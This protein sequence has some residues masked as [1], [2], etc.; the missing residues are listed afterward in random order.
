MTLTAGMRLGPYE[1]VAPL[2]AGGMGEVYRARDTKLD[3]DVAVKVLPDGVAADAEALARFE[4]EAKAVAAVSHPNVLAI[5][6]FG[7]DRD[8][9]YIVTELLEGES[10]RQ[11]LQQ[12]SIPWRKAV[13]VGTS[14]ADGLAAAH[15]KGIIHRDLKPENIFLTSDG[16][17]KILDF[18][19]ARAQQAS[20]PDDRTITL[21]TKPGTVLGTVHY[22]SPEQVRGRPLDART[23]IFSLG[24]VLFEMITG[25]RAFR[26]DTSADITT[27]ILTQDPATVSSTI[28]DVVPDL[29]RTIAR[30][31]EKNARQRFQSS[32]D[33]AFTLRSILSGSGSGIASAAG[34]GV[35]GWKWAVGALIVMLIVAAGFIWRPIRSPV[36]PGGRIDSLL[37][38]PFVEQSGETDAEFLGE[39]IAESVINSLLTMPNL[40]VIPRNT[41]IRYK[42]R[43]QEL[44]VIASELNVRAVLTGRVRELDGRL[45]VRASLEDTKYRRQIWGEEY[46]RPRSDILTIERDIARRISDAL[47]LQLSGEDV[48]RR[49]KQHTDNPEAY[50][51]YARGRF[52]WNKRTQGGFERAIALYDD[53]IRIDPNYALAYAG[54]ADSYLLLGVYHYVRPRGAFPQALLAVQTALLIDN[55]LAEAHTAL[56]GIRIWSEWDWDG[57]ETAF[58]RA[59]ELAPK[60]PTAHHWY[61]W[62]LMAMQRHEEA[63]REMQRA[64][65]LDPG[66]LI[67]NRDVGSQYLFSRQLDRAIVQFRRT[68]EM[69]PNFATARLFLGQALRQKQ[70]YEEAIAEFQK[71]IDLV[72]LVLEVVG[73]LAYTYALADRVDEALAE[74]RR[75]TELS[76]ERYVPAGS[77]ALIHIGLGNKDQAF[78]WLEKAYENREYMVPLLNVSPAYDSLR[79]DPRFDDLL[80]RVGLEGVS[81]MRPAP[82]LAVKSETGKVKLV[83]L[84]FEDISPAPEAWFGDGLTE[85]LIAQLSRLSPDK[86][87]VIASTTAMQYKGTDKRVRQIGRELDIDYVVEGRVQRIDDRVRI[88]TR[89]VR[90]SD[91]THVWSEDFDRKIDDVFAL[92]SEVVSRI[93]EGIQM[94]L[95]PTEEAQL[96]RARPVDPDALDAYLEGIALAKDGTEQA[97]RSALKMFD[98]AIESDPKFALAHVGRADVFVTL[99]EFHVPP[100]EAMPYAKTAALDALALDEGLPE[101]LTALARVQ[102]MF[103]WDFPTAE[104]T[105][106]RAMEL[107]GS[108]TDARL[109]YAVYLTAMKRGDEAIRQLDWVR[110]RD[111]AS[112]Y[113]YE[114][115][116]LVAYMTRRYDRV[117]RDCSAAI[118]VD[119]E[120]WKARSWLGLAHAQRGELAEG[121]HHLRKALTQSDNSPVVAAMLGS[122][123]AVSG[124]QEEARTIV[125]EVKKRESSDYVCPY[126]LATVWIGLDDHDEAFAEMDRACDGRAPCMPWLQVD[127]RLDPIRSDPRFDDLLRRVGFE[128]EPPLLESVEA[129][130]EKTMLAVLPFENISRNPQEWFSDG[131][132]E[133]MIAQLGRLQPKKLGVIARTS[134]MQYK[135]TTK[136]VDQIGRELGVDYILEGSVRRALN[137]VRITAQLIQVSDQTQLWAQSFERDIADVFAVQAEVAEHIANALAVEL[138]PNQQAALARRATSN[139]AA[140]EACMIGRY[141]WNKFTSEGYAKAREYFERAIEED[142]NYAP[143]YAWLANAYGVTGLYGSVPPKESLPIAKEFAHKAL[144]IDDT[145]PIGHASLGMFALFY[146]WNWL[147]AEREL[148]RA[149]EL[150][151]SYA[152]A[153]HWYAL[154]LTVMGRHDEALAEIKQARALDPL[155]LPINVAVGRKHYFARRYDR[156]IEELNGALELDQDFSYAHHDLG[157]AYARKGMFK[158]ALREFQL[159]NYVEWQGYAH[160]LAGSSE[161]ATAVIN[162]LNDKAQEEYVS[163]YR[164]AVVYVGLG[165]KDQALAALEQAYTDRSGLLVWLNVEPAFDPLREDPRFDDLLRRIGFE[166]QA[167]PV[168]QT[169]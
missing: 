58:R 45:I 111:P 117:I 2:G 38:L 62:Y 37:V 82:G 163:P 13:D 123:L 88:F 15:A 162:R 135:S 84:P 10:L 74:L 143:A 125:N 19:L 130:R 53:A 49:D 155:S 78:E 32:G 23:D 152:E 131:M 35:G 65:Q 142:P 124:E 42:G 93:A 128:P 160:A 97:C 110:E 107:N 167:I 70:L 103:E 147:E 67:I 169:P 29:D 129:P 132:T 156:A 159:G 126:E 92:Q 145:L 116:G 46:D 54:K 127:P 9:T 16:V 148:E 140:R 136:S 80:R 119:P 4:R 90:A 44:D 64:Q 96:A 102:M 41:A 31:L 115:H 122:L 139:P 61:G 85:T 101:A 153:H 56:G 66:S 18:G 8:I 144:E 71:T 63:A 89:L 77:F 7:T 113:T 60:Y 30:C 43:E 1:I 151:P 146:D 20:G 75:L 79:S 69:D 95:T 100:V 72:G 150:N 47:R 26:G 108:S 99:G 154:F 17:V 14:V 87:S 28:V 138:L 98:Q 121:I 51:A 161:E 149:I 57:A 48:A 27:A 25:E 40:R 59:I 12:S 165:E 81:P 105:F 94:Q 73:D 137:R 109:G 112:V 5:Y 141:H 120:F 86:L 6:D 24:C 106:E 3:R 157:K 91:E 50:M 158:E 118:D 22:M 34:K 36:Q 166:P 52:W 76:K 33:L 164:L 11:R 104:E 134:A 133:E 83:V 68:I 55:A 39:G 21:D 114:Y 168:E